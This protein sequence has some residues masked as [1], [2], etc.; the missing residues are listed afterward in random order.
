MTEIID[1]SPVFN[2]S[3]NQTE[4]HYGEVVADWNGGFGALWENVR[5]VGHSVL[6][7]FGLGAFNSVDPAQSTRSGVSVPADL[8]TWFYDAALLTG[9]AVATVWQTG[10]FQSGIHLWNQIL[11][12]DG[13]ALSPAQEVSA[14]SSVT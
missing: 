8:T 14:N 9:G 7:G 13:N 6:T 4:D 1:F 10:D 12:R 5:W 11:D 2:L 3:P